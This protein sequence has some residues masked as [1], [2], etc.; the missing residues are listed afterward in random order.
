M[1]EEF[2]CQILVSLNERYGPSIWPI[3][4]KT[5]AGIALKLQMSVVYKSSHFLAGLPIENAGC[6]F[7]NCIDF[8]PVFTFLNNNFSIL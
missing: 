8:Q 2:P 3:D 1:E 4:K 6:V 5:A 7:H